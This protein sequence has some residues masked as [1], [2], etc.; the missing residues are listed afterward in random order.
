MQK[1]II[2]E[3]VL[4]KFREWDKNNYKIILTTGRKE[5]NRTQ[6]EEQLKILG[7]NY[8]SLI[9]G[10]PNGERILINDKKRKRNNK[11]CYCN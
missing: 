7:I 11:Y 8:D 6:T 3:G 5:G 10:L 1:P 4:D 2:L 9:M